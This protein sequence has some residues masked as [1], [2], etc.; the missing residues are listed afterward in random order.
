MKLLS[1]AGGVWA[2]LL[3][4]LMLPVAALQADPSFIYSSPR[5]GAILVS[6]GTR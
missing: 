6:P 2:L 3:T 5:P 1:V 4:G